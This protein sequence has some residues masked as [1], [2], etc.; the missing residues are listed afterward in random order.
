[1]A[2]ILCILNARI[3]GELEE[4]E[5]NSKVAQVLVQT[6]RISKANFSNLSFW[7]EDDENVN[8]LT[9]KIY[10][11][12][13]GEEEYNRIE[14]LKTSLFELNQD[15]EVNILIKFRDS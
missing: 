14:F 15:E 7:F 3:C 2:T 1:L 13:D 6:V 4:N 11:Y 8:S 12:L 9:C 5:L 10:S